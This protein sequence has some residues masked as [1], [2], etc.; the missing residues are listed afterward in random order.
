MKSNIN[1]YKLFFII[2]LYRPEGRI[3]IDALQK[4]N[5]SRYRPIPIITTA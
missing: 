2:P 4:N 3:F 5:T 1:N